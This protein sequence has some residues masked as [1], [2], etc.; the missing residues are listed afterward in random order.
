MR[1]I[2]ACRPAG[3]DFSLLVDRGFVGEGVA[4]R[5]RVIDTTLPLVLMGEFRT[6]PSLA[7]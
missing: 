2:S 7:A 5:P 6:V 1:L 3:Q 4:T